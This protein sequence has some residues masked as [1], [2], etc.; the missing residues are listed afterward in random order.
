MITT[1]PPVSLSDVMAEL[2]VV[3]PGRAHPIA[4][5]DTDVRTLAGVPAGPISLTNLLG[6]STYTAMSGSIANVDAGASIDPF[7]NYTESVPV[8]LSL[9]GGLPAYTYVWTKLSGAG[10][11]NAV[12][13]ASAT[14]D[15]FVNRFAAPGTVLMCVVQCAVTDGLGNT[16][17][18][19]G[20]VTLTL[21]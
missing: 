20:T 19:T 2:R 15:F 3:N 17:T 18:R 6:K 10:T 9:A 11:L 4:L 12:N 14:V 7:T 21:D 16:L 13:A 8:S 1:T 5:G